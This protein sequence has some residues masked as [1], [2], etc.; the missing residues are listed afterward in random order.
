MKLDAPRCLALFFVGMGTPLENLQTLTD[1]FFDNR[2]YFAEKSVTK[3]K[4]FHSAIVGL[5]AYPKRSEHAGTESHEFDHNS[6]TKLRQDVEAWLSLNDVS[7]T[8]TTGAGSS[9][10]IHDLSDFRS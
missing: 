5:L 9:F 3:A 1:A 4:A 7:T 6:L 8:S 2:D 10:V